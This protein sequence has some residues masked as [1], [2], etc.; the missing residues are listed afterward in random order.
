[1]KYKTGLS[2]TRKE[3]RRTDGSSFHFSCHPNKPSA[4]ESTSLNIRPA[5]KDEMAKEKEEEIP[6]LAI[7]EK[8]S[9]ADHKGKLVYVY[10]KDGNDYLGGV[11]RGQDK[12]TN[13]YDVELQVLLKPDQI[14]II[15]QKERTPK[16]KDVITQIQRKNVVMN[17]FARYKREE[18]GEPG[19]VASTAAF[20]VV[21]ASEYKEIRYGWHN[22]CFGDRDRP[23]MDGQTTTITMRTEVNG[24]IVD[25][26]LL[27]TPGEAV[28]AAAIGATL[29]APP[30]IVPPCV[31][32]APSGSSDT[33]VVI[34]KEE[35][36]EVDPTSC[37]RVAALL[38]QPRANQL[39]TLFLKHKIDASEIGKG[40]FIDARS[41]AVSVG[42]E[43]GKAYAPAPPEMLRSLVAKIHG[44]DPKL[45]TAL[46]IGEFIQ[47]DA[48]VTLEGLATMPIAAHPDLTINGK[49]V[50]T[51]APLAMLYDK[52][53]DT[54]WLLN[55]VDKGMQVTMEDLVKAYACCRVFESILNTPP[56]PTGIAV[57]FVLRSQY[58]VELLQFLMKD[59]S[60]AVPIFDGDYVGEVG[61]TGKRT[62]YSS[63]DKNKIAAPQQ[64][65]QVVAAQ[66][67]A[68]VK[69]Q[70]PKKKKKS[71]FF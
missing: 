56:Q 43:T 11:V 65:Q 48:M 23:G 31:M 51:I 71:G 58:K 70:Q 8:T 38:M 34:V 53:I 68:V 27:P 19:E 10:G 39:R 26:R 16:Q 64:V 54:L 57:A 14:K 21:T 60:P 69:Q 67:T 33:T 42:V 1:V 37:K 28:Q 4:F 52:K 41:H 32:P 45:T 36:E 63:K 55:Y 13:L 6:F 5:P 44:T 22:P 35:E 62:I 25:P 15:P 18:L 9:V 3:R 7:V 24:T 46:V 29:F 2:G 61:P 59:Y 49:R 17:A 66:P 40:G 47:K 12:A 20:P 50:Y 30:S